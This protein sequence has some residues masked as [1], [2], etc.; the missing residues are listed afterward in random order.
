MRR[1]SSLLQY[2]ICNSSLVQKNRSAV[3]YF[4]CALGSSLIEENVFQQQPCDLPPMWLTIS[5]GWKRPY[6]WQPSL[7]WLKE[8]NAMQLQNH[9]NR[10]TKCYKPSKAAFIKLLSQSEPSAYHCIVFWTK[11]AAA[12][13]QDILD[14][15]GF[16]YEDF[17][18]DSKNFK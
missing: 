4:T 17:C 7:L 8:S 1:K 3:V 10:M 15:D 14:Q 13:P 11:E 16:L 12:D 2:I 9:L 18:P 6:D 5:S